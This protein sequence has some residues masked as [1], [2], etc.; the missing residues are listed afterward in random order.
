MRKAL[1]VGSCLI[2]FTLVAAFSAYFDAFVLEPHWLEVERITIVHPRLAGVL[3]GL[4]VAQLSDIHLRG[5][6]GFL[7]SAIIE[8]VRRVDPDVLIMNGDLVSRR[9]ALRRFWEFAGAMRPR[10]WTYAIPGDTDDALINDSW[11][12]D[13]WRRAG[14]ALLVDEVVPVIWPGTGE[15]RLWLIAATH[16][17]DWKAVS[18]RIPD[19]EPVVVLA[20]KPILVKQ[21]V[22]AGADLVLAGDTH[23]AQLGVPSLSRLSPYARRGPYVAGLYGVKKTL[24]YV[25]RGTGWT[26]RPMR[27]FC[28]P[29]LTVF[30]F[31]PE[32]EMRNIQV[33]PG[34]E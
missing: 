15:K 25:N 28:R 16:A 18:A 23:G 9:S 5:K 26:A 6:P 11:E 21:A 2:A 12:D 14:I 1:V 32:G 10:I 27:F 13:G 20:E 34:D 17:L 8:A 3:G 33:L 19:G 30:N 29:E 7:E 22:L 24:L 4:S 31:V